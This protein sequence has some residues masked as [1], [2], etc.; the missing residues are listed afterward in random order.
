[1]S[2]QSAFALVIFNFLF[3][4]LTFP[5]DGHLSKKM[6]LL[7]IGN[8]LGWLWNWLFHMLIGTIVFAVGDVFY[9]VYLILNPFANLLWI[10][11]FWSLSLTVLTSAHEEKTVMGLDI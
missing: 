1:V 10:V 4:S 11:S 3:V 8:G 7:L 2:V 9:P 5:L 6:C